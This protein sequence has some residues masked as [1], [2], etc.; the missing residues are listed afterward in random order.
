MAGISQHCKTGDVVAF[1]DS[2]G[3]AS[4]A[5]C[6]LTEAAGQVRSQHGT[7]SLFWVSMR[8]LSSQLSVICSSVLTRIWCSVCSEWCITSKQPSEQ[9]KQKETQTFLRGSVLIIVTLS[10]GNY[11]VIEM[12]FMFFQ[13]SAI[14]MRHWMLPP[15]N[16]QLP[17]LEKGASWKI[18]CSH[19]LSA[20]LFTMCTL[21][22]YASIHA[23]GGRWLVWNNKWDL[24]GQWRTSLVANWQVNMFFGG[25][26][27]CPT[28]LLSCRCVRSS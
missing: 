4:K 22:I 10:T 19:C 20:L 1:G 5:L 26:T 9:Y 12:M 25:V 3:V 11:S 13:T 18:F 8:L 7:N 15:C 23:C 27:F 21:W 6:G 16:I 28:G 14:K 17:C 24:E 2:V